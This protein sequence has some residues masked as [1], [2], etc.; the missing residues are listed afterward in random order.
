MLT[1]FHLLDFYWFVYMRFLTISKEIGV[2]LQMGGLKLIFYWDCHFRHQT[3]SKITLKRGNQQQRKET[4]FQ[5]S[6]EGSI[7]VHDMKKSESE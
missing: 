6:L 2:L 7:E 3:R 5:A 1:V 4:F